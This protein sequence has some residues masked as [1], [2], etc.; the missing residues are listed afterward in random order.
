MILNLTH[1]SRNR[2]WLRF[3][4]NNSFRFIFSQYGSAL[5]NQ[6]FDA[7]VQ[8]SM[9]PFSGLG[10]TFNFDLL[11]KHFGPS[12]V[13]KCNSLQIM[14]IGTGALYTL[15]V[16]NCGSSVV[17]LNQTNFQGSGP[18]ALMTLARPGGAVSFTPGPIVIAK[19]LPT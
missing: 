13:K 14:G 7:S 3:F 10:I 15:V 5:I 18:D 12:Q 4:S 16:M 19:S 1:P 9:G 2:P 11:Y 8:T 6:L 17:I